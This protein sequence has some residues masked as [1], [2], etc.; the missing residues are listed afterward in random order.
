MPTAVIIENDIAKYLR[1]KSKPKG[2]ELKKPLNCALYLDLNDDAYKALDNDPLLQAKVTEAASSKYKELVEQ[3]VAKLNELDAAY[4]KSQSKKERAVILKSFE[5]YAKK[6]LSKFTKVAKK[7]AETAW[8]K[9]AKTKSD[10]TK[11]KVKAGVNLAIDGLNV[12]GGI[13]GSIGTGG[14]GLI[15]SIYGIL[16]T[17]VSMSMQVYK[18]AIDAD[19]MQKKVTKGLSKVQKSFDKKKK[20]VSGAKNSGKAFINSLLGADFIPTISSVKSDNDQYKSKLQGV[21][22]NSHKL[23]KKLQE[24]LKEMDKVEKMP[25]VKSSKKVKALL[26]KLQSSTSKLLDKIIDM[27]TKCNEGYEFQKKTDSAISELET[28]EPK[29]WKVINKGMVVIDIVMAGGDFSKAGEAVLGIG[30]AIVS[31]VDKELVDRV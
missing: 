11:Y 30:T 6:S 29:K 5:G 19:K 27:Q 1:E 13:A 9:V 18:L 20:E 17:L 22:V 25:D 14:F 2:I 23:S 15:V 3:M 7:E 24:V 31:E 16:K 28:L 4:V 10:Y 26:S 21:D 8:D 12:V